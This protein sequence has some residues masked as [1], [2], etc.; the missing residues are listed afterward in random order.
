MTQE[1]P[2][3]EY[4]HPFIRLNVTAWNRVEPSS[5]IVWHNQ[6]KIADASTTSYIYIN[7]HEIKRILVGTQGILS[8]FSILMTDNTAYEYLGHPPNIALVHNQF[9]KMYEETYIN[10]EPVKQEGRQ[11]PA[12]DHR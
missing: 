8:V 7:H 1:R 4:M 10:Y 3:I 11:W 2:F 9:L 5:F 12:S 6:S